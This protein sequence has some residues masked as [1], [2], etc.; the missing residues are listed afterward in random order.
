[1][2]ILVGGASGFIGKML[3]P[4]LGAKGAKLVLLG[5]DKSKLQSIFPKNEVLSYDE[6]LDASKNADLFLNLAVLNNDQS[7]NSDAMD[8]VNAHFAADL[9]KSAMQGGVKRFVNVSSIHALDPNDT[10][11]Y[12]SSKRAGVSA[13]DAATGGM[14][15]H[16]Y[17]PAV[18]GEKFAGALSPLN[19]LPK[20][21]S[22]ALL[23][24][25]SA[26]KPVLPVGELADWVMQQ[27]MTAERH[28]V[29]T[30][31]QRNNPYYAIIGRGLDIFA[32]VFGLVAFS[33][34]L[35][36]T[37]CLIKMQSDG[38]GIFAQER[39]GRYGRAFT[40][41]KFRTMA[42]GTVQAGTHEVSGSSVTP[43][44]SRLRRLKIDELPQLWN[45]LKGDMSLVGPR[46]C[47]P[48][49]EELVKRRSDAGVLDVRPGISGLAQVN[50][51]DM[52][53]PQQLVEWDARYIAL[54]GLIIDI[55]LILQTV[56]GGGRGDRVAK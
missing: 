14:A 40:C 2:K 5:R 15:I 20:P 55:K 52:S 48:S 39:V 44:G 34:V 43:L 30:K 1:M 26:L 16:L 7:Q 38:P 45:V 28:V 12:A 17:L 11:P 23:G 24:P 54:R 32:S 10:R 53:N 51:I 27:A 33:P 29:L 46:P 6:L 18:I 21:V 9:A 47:L 4:E 3:V 50:G 25:L 42:V 35:L 8:F 36:A 41:Y 49:Q 31:G 37:W 56:R 22:R 13:V 19:A